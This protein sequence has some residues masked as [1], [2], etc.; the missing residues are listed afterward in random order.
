[1]H[2]YGRAAVDLQRSGVNGRTAEIAGRAGYEH[3]AR[4]VLGNPAGGNCAEM[5][6]TADDFAAPPVN[7]PPASKMPPALLT[8]IDPENLICELLELLSPQIVPP[9]STHFL[10]I[11]LDV[12]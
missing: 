10:F 8:V 6:K 3:R 11:A 5:V 1:M 12:L 2:G 9:L 4:P 7:P